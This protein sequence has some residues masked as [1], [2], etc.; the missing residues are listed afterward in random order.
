MDMRASRV[1]MRICMTMP[2]ATCI[3][4]DCKRVPVA[5]AMHMH[6]HMPVARARY[7]VRF[8]CRSELFD[9]RSLT[10]DSLGLGA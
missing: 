6:M 8:S 3:C 1:Y 9:E 2:M 10:T 4:I 5:R 7:L